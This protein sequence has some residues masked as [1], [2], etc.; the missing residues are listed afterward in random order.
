MDDNIK[1][2]ILVIDLKEIKEHLKN[3]NKRGI[4]I[5]VPKIFFGD[6]LL[7]GIY[8]K[9]S[10]M[11]KPNKVCKSSDFIDKNLPWFPDGPFAISFADENAEQDTHCH[12]KHW[13]IYFSEK[14]FGAH[15]IIQT[16]E[17]NHTVPTKEGDIKLPNGGAIL[18]GPGVIHK[19]ELSGLT[20]VIE[21]PAV[22]NDKKKFDP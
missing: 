3:N 1:R 8:W 22:F 2:K 4:K 16:K 17:G 20:M 7:E 14:D 11:T 18:F 12:E 19:M 5:V 9:H 15:Y 21:V 13:E 6:S 10:E